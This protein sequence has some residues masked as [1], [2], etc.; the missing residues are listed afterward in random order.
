MEMEFQQMDFNP[1]FLYE[2]RYVIIDSKMV[3]L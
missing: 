1:I 3:I 2:D